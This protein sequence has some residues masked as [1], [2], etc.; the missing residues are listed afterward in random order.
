MPP[1]T[2]SAIQ[3]SAHNEAA[4]TKNANLLEQLDMET[5]TVEH[6]IRERV[7][8]RPEI[9]IQIDRRWCYRWR[10]RW[11]WRKRQTGM[12]GNFLPYDHHLMRSVRQRVGMLFERA[13]AA[14]RIHPALLLNYDQVWKLA[15][16]GSQWKYY[17]EPIESGVRARHVASGRFTREAEGAMPP[18]VGPTRKRLR[19]KQQPVHD[20][21]SNQR[22]PHTLCTSTWSDGTAGPLLSVW[23][24]GA[25]PQAVVAQANKEFAGR[26]LVI[27]TRTDSHF[28]T[29][30]STVQY[31]EE[32]ITLV[33]Q[34]P[35]GA[36][37]AEFCKS[38]TPPPLPPTPAS[39][40]RCAPSVHPWV[41]TAAPGRRS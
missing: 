26:M 32:L 2:T 37:I 41:W 17:K 19:G 10:K 39:A 23:Q 21:V 27:V 1:P 6:A 28:M 31:F 29:G 25:I 13:D 11:G 3:V 15:H 8:M 38:Y 24:E 9:K 35:N 40:R 20:P 22:M 30:E 7:P 12:T 5:V 14:T 18:D 36:C 34:P 4:K 33:P 16:R